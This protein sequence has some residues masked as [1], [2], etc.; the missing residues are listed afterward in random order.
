ML[1]LISV[2]KQCQ[3]FRPS[4][5]FHRSASQRFFAESSAPINNSH[6]R[7]SLL[8]KSLESL[9]IDVESLADAVT[10][11]VENP[12]KGYDGR[13]GKSAIKTYRSFVSP[14][15]KLSDSEYS[16][17]L[18]VMAD[19]CARQIEFLLKRHEAHQ[20][21]WVRHH[22]AMV[23]DRKVFPLVLV[24]DNLR[25]AFNVGSIFRTA[26]AA[27]CSLVITAGITP[28]PHA[29][30][31]DKLSKSALGAEKLVPSKHFTSTQEALDY[32]RQAIPSYQIYG[33]ET[34]SRSECYANVTYSRDDGV[35]LVVGNE[36][37]GVATEIL[38]DLDQ[39]IEIPMYGAK[40]S[41]NVAACVPVVLYEVL[42]QWDTK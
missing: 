15:S 31:A 41:L 10:Q 9:S 19:R 14:T 5:V 13:F 30:G 39:I 34:T 35:V 29:S 11:S 38:K 7:E 6:E 23:Q 37:T 17:K 1:A 28:S 3:P 26:D 21:D 18:K 36:V 25:S 33:M 2:A 27:G 42:R 24:L 8:R 40:N 4:V 22:D 16:D 32:V 20:A 12:A